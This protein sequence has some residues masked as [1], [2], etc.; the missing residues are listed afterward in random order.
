[1]ESSNPAGASMCQGQALVPDRALAGTQLYGV[2]DLLSLS[3]SPLGRSWAFPQK[4]S[5]Q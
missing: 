4:G 1:M 2:V 3:S 5:V